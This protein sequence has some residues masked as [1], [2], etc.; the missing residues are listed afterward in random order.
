MSSCEETCLYL[1]ID[2]TDR[3]LGA[4]YDTGQDGHPQSGNVDIGEILSSYQGYHDL[5]GLEFPFQLWISQVFRI[6]N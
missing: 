4:I 2:T 6:G 3:D 1:T 5:L